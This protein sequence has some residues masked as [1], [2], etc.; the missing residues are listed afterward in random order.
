[1]SQ[2]PTWQL[3]LQESGGLILTPCPGTK[4]VAL[5]ESLQQLKEQGASIV[6]TAINQQEMA[7]HQ[8]ETLGKEVKALGMQW[9]HL[10][11]EDD[12]APDEQF[13]TQWL[14]VKDQVKADLAQGNQVVLHCLGGSG[15]TGLLAAH[16]L[17]D[18]GWQLQN[19]IE[20]VQARRP[21]AFT[22]PVQLE[23]INTL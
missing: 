4:D 9:I 17:L 20:Q 8:V 12:C 13:L 5:I 1:M 2:H 19:I 3:P 15:R 18:H 11:I 10:P 6:I 14:A 23:Y 21:G 16:I 22:K 7:K